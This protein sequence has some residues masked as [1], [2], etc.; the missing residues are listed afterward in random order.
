M[1]AVVLL[2]EEI[3]NPTVLAHL[4]PA[5][6]PFILKH[7]VPGELLGD[8]TDHLL[9]GECL[10]TTGAMKRDFFVENTGLRLGESGQVQS[11]FKR[12]GIFRTGLLTKAALQAGRFI[13]QQTRLTTATGHGLGRT[14]SRTGHTKRTGITI[15]NNLT[16]WRSLGE[17]RGC[18]VPIRTIEGAE[19]GLKPFTLA[20]G[21]AE[22]TG[23]PAMIIV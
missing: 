17:R 22:V 20:P 9:G 16:E 21:N 3:L 1:Q 6:R 18:L 12:N 7:P 2:V 19:G 4:K 13:K 15:N 10:A 14:D 11:R 5:P 23:I 8:P